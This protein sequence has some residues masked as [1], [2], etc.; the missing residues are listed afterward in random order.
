[1]SLGRRLQPKRHSSGHVRETEGVPRKAV[2]SNTATTQMDAV[3]LANQGTF[4]A[5]EAMVQQIRQTGP[6]VWVAQQM[7]TTR[8]ARGTIRPQVALAN[9]ARADAR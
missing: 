5:T 8:S 7:A 1:M 6:L 9:P 4:G 2:L 3:R